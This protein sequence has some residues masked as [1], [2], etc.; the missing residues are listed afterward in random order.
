MNQYNDSMNPLSHLTVSRCGAVAFQANYGLKI[1]CER[2]RLC[3]AAYSIQVEILKS[4]THCMESNKWESFA[5]TKTLHTHDERRL[6][7]HGRRAREQMTINSILFIGC[8]LARMCGFLTCATIAWCQPFKS[9]DSRDISA[10]LQWSIESK[11]GNMKHDIGIY[12]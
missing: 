10:A 8:I 5:H 6:M 4:L 12:E 3:T 7:L 2:G 11:Q 1:M 9:I